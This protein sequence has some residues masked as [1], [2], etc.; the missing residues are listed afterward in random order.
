MLIELTKLKGLSV[1]VMDESK[2]GGEISQII[3]DFSQSKVIGF[4][5]KTGGFFSSE[6]VV[7]LPDVVSIDRD[8]AVINTSDDILEKDEIV[9]VDTILKKNAKL[10]G[11][12]A[13]D[14]AGVL[15]GFVYDG[16]FETDTGDLTRLYVGRLWKKYIFSRN[17]IFDLNEKKVVIDTDSK[18]KDSVKPVLGVAEV[19]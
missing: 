6:K 16:V 7:S 13:Y 11:L 19:V 5:V 8:G 12:R 2:K 14:R 10:V 17:R 4:L 3:F 18:I 9:R 1:G 15:L